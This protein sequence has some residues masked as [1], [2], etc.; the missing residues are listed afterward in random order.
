[1]HVNHVL[2]CKGCAQLLPP[3]TGPSLESWPPALGKAGFTPY[4]RHSEYGQ[5]AIIRCSEEIRLCLWSDGFTDAHGDCGRV[6]DLSVRS[7]Q[8][9]KAG[10][11]H[12]TF[13]KNGCGKRRETVHVPIVT[14]GT[15]GIG[16]SYAEELAKR[17]MKIVLISRSQD[18]LNQVSSAIKEK[19]KVE[20]R[21]IA[22]DFALDDIY[23]KIKT[24][25]A[26]LEIGVL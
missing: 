14:G 18:K 22:V 3:L 2:K 5:L 26:G 19:F 25:L 24:G 13:L 1:D 11:Q 21:T 17:G 12:T 10:Y 15:D 16:K 8:V 4:L 20:T 23:D 6:G 7:S 9:E